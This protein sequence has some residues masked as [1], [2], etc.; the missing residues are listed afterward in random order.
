MDGVDWGNIAILLVVSVALLL[1]A[2]ALFER[3]DIY[4]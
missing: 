1:A 4:T 3:R 2:I